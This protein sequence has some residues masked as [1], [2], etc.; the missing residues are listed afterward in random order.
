M[1]KTL[2]RLAGESRVYRLH[3]AEAQP[4]IERLAADVEDVRTA[5]LLTSVKALRSNRLGTPAHVEDL[6][7]AALKELQE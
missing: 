2:V 6:A 7:L 1:L 3:L 5:M 4:V